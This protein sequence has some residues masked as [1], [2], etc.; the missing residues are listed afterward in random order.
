[1]TEEL[2]LDAGAFLAWERGDQRVRAVI[3]LARSGRVSLRTSAAVVAQVWRG[4][5]RQA[6]LSRLLESGVVEERPLDP[7]AGRRVGVLA[8]ATGESDVVDGH[9]ASIALE[10][11]ARVVTSDPVDLRRWGVP[12]EALVV[13]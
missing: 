12:E 5:A 4:G 7:R 6:R 9:V 8:A 3:A 2:V 13:C 10:R 11:H 1:M